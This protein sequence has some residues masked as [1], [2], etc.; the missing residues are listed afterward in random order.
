[1][2]RLPL[3]LVLSMV[4]G[5]AALAADASKFKATPLQPGA[6]YGVGVVR[7]AAGAKAQAQAQTPAEKRIS[8]IVKLADDSLAAYKGGLS[9]LAAT[10]PVVT[11]A[12]ELDVRSTDSKK[13]LTY[14]SQRQG[15]FAASTSA[16]SGAEVKQRFD[17][18]FGGVQMLVPESQ[19]DALRALPGV[20]AVYI[21]ELL[22]PDTNI[23]RSSS[24]PPRS[25]RSSAAR[26]RLAKLSWSACSI[27]ASGRS[28]RPIR[29]P[30]RPATATRPR[31]RAGMAPPASSATWRTTWMTRPSPA[32]TS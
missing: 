23:S 29:I 14:L 26:K 5:A 24:A 22:Q 8:V 6:T 32:T 31:R 16:I 10:S 11:G 18:V 27:P 3:A 15:A 1:M 13:Y 7:P 21:D 19:L 30:I 4:V 17:V 12:K 28:I 25:G 9:G 2:S 20:K